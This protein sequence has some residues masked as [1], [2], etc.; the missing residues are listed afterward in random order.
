MGRLVSAAALVRDQI[1]LYNPP[2]SVT[3]ATGVPSSM[4]SVAVFVNNVP[5]AWT[6]Q[7]GTTTADAA[8]SAGTVFF[9]EIS[10]SP[11]YYSVRFFPDRVGYW[12]L[13][14]FDA[15]LTEEVIKEYDVVPAGAFSPGGGGNGLNAS[16][17]P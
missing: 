14:F 3:R 4:V 2:G 6:L 17:T 12:R 15:A 13:V 9:N 7:D 16:F 5:L 8:I 10:G 11:G 1:D